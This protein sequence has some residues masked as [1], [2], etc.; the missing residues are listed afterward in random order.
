MQTLSKSAMYIEL[1]RLRR[2]NQKRH[3]HKRDK[4]CKHQTLS[5]HT[6]MRRP[7][8]T[9]LC[10]MIEELRAIDHFIHLTFSGPVNGLAVRGHR[11]FS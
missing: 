1:T 9:N 6:E 11:K 7:I 4:K 5:H 8:S 3:Q 2:P 10:V